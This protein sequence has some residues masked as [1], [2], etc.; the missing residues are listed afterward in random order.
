M[1]TKNVYKEYHRYFNVRQLARLSFPPPSLLHSNLAHILV[2][3]CPPN[4]PSHVGQLDLG[5]VYVLAHVPPQPHLLARALKS[6][7]KWASLPMRGVGVF[8][9]T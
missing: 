9:H 4:I 6:S 3:H 1:K 2:K 8:L 7:H 5:N